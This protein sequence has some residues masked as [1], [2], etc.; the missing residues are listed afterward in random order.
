[1]IRLFIPIGCLLFFAAWIL[2]HWL[3]KKD[4]K[5]RQ[6]GLFSGLFFI[7]IWLIIYLLL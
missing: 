7:G 2:Y 1:M 5:K 4:L 3:F 6:N